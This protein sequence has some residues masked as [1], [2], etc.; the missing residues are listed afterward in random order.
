MNLRLKLIDRYRQWR[1]DR[2]CTVGDHGL[3]I[4]MWTPNLDG[5]KSYR[6]CF[7]CGC[8]VMSRPRTVID[9]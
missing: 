9:Q 4:S 8:K 5:T 6:Y 7:N 1:V 2:A 3:T